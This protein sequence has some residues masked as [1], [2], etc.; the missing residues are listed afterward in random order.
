VYL[1]YEENICAL[2]AIFAGLI[3]LGNILV[4]SIVRPIVF[5][6]VPVMRDNS[7]LWQCPE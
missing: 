1:G 2:V 7:Y 3:E 5:A 6:Y 4:A